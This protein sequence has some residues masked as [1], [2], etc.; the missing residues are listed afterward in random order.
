MPG[1]VAFV[2]KGYPRL[3]ETFVANEIRALERR[4]LDI[5]IVSLRRPADG[6][7]QPVHGEI[8]APVLYLPEYLHE[9]PRRVLRGLRAAARRPGFAAARAAWLEDLA[10]D[11]TPNRARRFGQAAVLAAELPEE[12]SWLHA[13]FLHTPASVARYAALMRGAGWSVS[14]HAKDVWTTPDWEKAGKLASC[15][16]AAACSHAAGRAL[17]ALAPEPSRVAVIHHGLDPERFPPPPDRAAQTRDG[18]DAADP[19][20]L[21]TVA[22]AVEK[23]GLDLIVEALAAL[24]PGLSW[25][26]THI[27]AGAG[28]ARLRRLARRRGVA[29]RIAWRGARAQGEV[30]A[31]YRAADL[32]VLACRVAA[33]GDRDGLPNVLVEAQSQA[34]ACLAT[35]EAA[36]PELI[37]DGKTGALVPPGDAASL[38]RALEAL[39]RSPARRE[40]LA[41][42]GAGRVGAAF[43]FASGIDRLA[44]LFGLPA[45]AP[46]ASR[47]TRR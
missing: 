20:R 29:D 41:R 47:S 31:A 7:R 18:S 30:L 27:G 6:Q 1:P 13:H 45:R 24:P 23:K 34:L 8:A 42:A 22:R 19:V 44:A 46:C 40:S 17:A 25:R 21:L 2:L 37:E 15:A 38:A 3:S 33:S 32:F 5:R 28:L 4:G 43:D 16:W 26:W 14:A 39:I 12:V 11:P 9:A 10:R 36:V 35:D